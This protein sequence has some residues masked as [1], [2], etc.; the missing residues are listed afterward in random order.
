MKRVTQ[1]IL[2]RESVVKY[3]LKYGNV[4][5]AIRFRRNRQYVWRW[6]KRYDGTRESLKLRSRRPHMHPTQHTEDERKMIVRMRKRNPH[7]GLVIFWVKLRQKGYRRTIT[8]LYRYMRKLGLYRVKLANPKKIKHGHYEAAL[9]PGR[10]I[11]IDVKV[12]PTACIASGC[13]YRRLYQYTALD[14][15]TRWR[16]V[17]AFPEQSTYSSAQ[18]VEQ[19]IRHFPFP[20]ECIQTDNGTEFT[21]R[22]TTYRNKPTMFERCLI[23]HGI[24]HHL[25]KPHTPRHNGKVERSHRKD[26][27]RFYAVRTF[28]SLQDFEKQLKRYNRIDYNRF[29]MQPLRWQSPEEVLKSFM[30]SA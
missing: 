14:E 21:N 2:Y 22:L 6:V 25:I 7:D 29:P 11:Q 27:E 15:C 30:P 10:K 24:R 1:D 17:A 9:Y 20:I 23:A 3:A 19:L 13:E 26:N 16:Y 18:F 28:Y 8:G 4:A 12:V 5:A